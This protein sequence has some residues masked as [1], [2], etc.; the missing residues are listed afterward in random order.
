MTRK[1]IGQDQLDNFSVDDETNQL[2]W[3][4]K[5]VV[6]VFAVP[7]WAK[8]AALAGGFG[9]ALSA[10]VNLIRLYLGK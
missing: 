2:Y 10:I 7:D 1:T 8:I 4:G 9:G 6:T 3:R 5:A